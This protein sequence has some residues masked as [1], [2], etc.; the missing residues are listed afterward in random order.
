MLPIGAAGSNSSPSAFSLEQ[1][2]NLI[3]RLRG[4]LVHGQFLGR[5]LVEALRA[6]TITALQSDTETAKIYEYLP[7][8]LL[9][10]PVLRVSCG[11]SGG[12]VVF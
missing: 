6:D 5:S 8:S 4:Y 1:L 9:R 12:V 3:L 2:L 10:L 11:D 7:S